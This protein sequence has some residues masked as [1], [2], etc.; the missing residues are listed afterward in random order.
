[1]I[2]NG[3]MF[4]IWLGCQ[5]LDLTST[6]IALNNPNL[7]EGNPIMHNRM[8]GNGLKIGINISA[9]IAYRKMSQ[10]SESKIKYMAPI[11]MGVSGCF[12]GI[13]NVRLIKSVK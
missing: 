3:I 1:M 12:A 2:M 8:I 4:G 6:N 5:S 11:A 13:S 9:L 10:K 7:A